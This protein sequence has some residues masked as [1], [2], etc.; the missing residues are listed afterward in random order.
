MLEQ[1]KA[2]IKEIE[3]AIQGLVANHTAW[4]AQLAEA[5]HFLSMAEQVTVEIAPDSLLTECVEVAAEIAQEVI[6]E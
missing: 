3:E 5:K 6:P 1:I 4:S 2:R